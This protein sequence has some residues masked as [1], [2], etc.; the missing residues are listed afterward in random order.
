MCE[1]KNK[2]CKKTKK[3]KTKTTAQSRLA[4]EVMTQKIHFYKLICH[5]WRE[6]KSNNLDF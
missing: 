3:N 2:T 4:Q 5:W 6:Y 1:K